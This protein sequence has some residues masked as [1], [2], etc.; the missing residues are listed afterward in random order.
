LNHPN[1]G[2]VALAVA[3][4]SAL[5]VAPTKRWV[6]KTSD[7]ALM[8]GDALERHASNDW[9]AIVLPVVKLRV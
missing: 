6:Y 1:L 9:A 4:L 5:D 7:I 2:L 3:P 8:T